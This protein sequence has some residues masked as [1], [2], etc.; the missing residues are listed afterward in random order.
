MQLSTCQLHTHT[1]SLLENKNTAGV[2]NYRGSRFRVK[3]TSSNRSEN[4]DQ[5]AAQVLE[6]MAFY[7]FMRSD[8]FQRAVH[9]GQNESYCTCEGDWV[10]RWWERNVVYTGAETWAA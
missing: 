3:A 8:D 10:T 4:D 5:E 9:G 6:Q 7:W 1:C 2:V